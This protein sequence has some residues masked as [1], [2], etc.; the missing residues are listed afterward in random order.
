MQ[1]EPRS[2]ALLVMDLQ[3]DIVAADGVFGSQGP[4]AAVAEAGV[5]TTCARALRVART[6]GLAVVHVGVETRDGQAVNTSAPQLAGLADPGVMDA[7]SPGTAFMPEVRPEAGELVVMKAA[8][9]AFA[10]TDLEV[11][12]RVRGIGHLVLCGFATNFVVEGTARQAVDM[13]YPVT[14][15]TDACCGFDVAAHKA[16]LEVLALL[17]TL[18]TTD[19]FAAAV[20]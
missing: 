1:Y 20:G 7:G 19:D 8:I 12:L 3:H 14:V 13:G 10:G 15:L 16:S 9:S 4:A 18:A 2:T 17:T 6:A 11:Q 5:L